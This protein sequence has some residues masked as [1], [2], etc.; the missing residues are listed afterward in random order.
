[1]KTPA[2]KILILTWQVLL[3][4]MLLLEM[5]AQVQVS[6]KR[7]RFEKNHAQLI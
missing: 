1:M 7:K 6:S 3:V 2:F 5:R 4:P